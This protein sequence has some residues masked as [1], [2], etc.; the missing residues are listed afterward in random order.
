MKAFLSS[1][2]LLTMTIVSAYG[3]LGGKIGKTPAVTNDWRTG[4]INITE[5]SGGIGLSET[6]ASYA[7]SYFGLTTIVGYQFSRNVKSGI[8]VGIQ[9]HN[10]GF[11]IPVFL[12]FRYSLNAQKVVPFI[13]GSGGVALAPEDINDLSRVFIN[14]VIGVRY[15]AG[16]KVALSFSTG[17]MV[18]SAQNYRTSFINFKLGGEFKWASY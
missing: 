6:S 12:D 2:L 11:L 13:A 17:V 9:S 15:V 3:Q 14:P 18:M 10:N 4:I 5:I 16:K 1:F 7:E 8:G